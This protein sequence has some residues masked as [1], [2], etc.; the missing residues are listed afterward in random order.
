[1]LHQTPITS[2][3]DPAN[4]LVTADTFAC[5][6]SAALNYSNG[7]RYLYLLIILIY[8]LQNLDKTYNPTFCLNTFNLIV[9]KLCTDHQMYV[10]EL[11]IDYF[12]LS[13]V[14]SSK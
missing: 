11:A 13:F 12:L 3:D 5:L 14:S 9:S 7:Y 8:Y 6:S 2:F 1:M 4:H 10:G